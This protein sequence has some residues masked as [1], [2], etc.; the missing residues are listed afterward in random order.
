MTEEL[1]EQELAAIEERATAALPGPWHS[2][3]LTGTLVVDALGREIVSCLAHPV[4]ALPTVEFIAQCRTDV[5][6][7]VAELRRLR[8][9]L[10]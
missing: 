6:R 5:P 2:D 4:N 9:L 3:P 7:L 10:G 1:S 8:A